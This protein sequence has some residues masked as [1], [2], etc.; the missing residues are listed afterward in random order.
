M[1]GKGGIELAVNGGF[2]AYSGASKIPAGWTAAQFTT[3]D[4]KDTVNKLEGSASLKITGLILARTKT[5]TQ[6]LTVSGAAGNAFTLSVWRSAHAIPVWDAGVQAQVLLYSGSV[7]KQTVSMAIP[8]GVYN[9]TQQKTMFIA[10][11]AYTKIVIKLIYPK[12]SGW[13]WFDGLSLL[14]SP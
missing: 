14:R 7:L 13:V 4:G 5:L 10:T 11:S 3:N 6:T 8:N 12:A 1:S 2:N 9:F